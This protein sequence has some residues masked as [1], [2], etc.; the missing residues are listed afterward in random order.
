MR[1]G[2][3][4]LYLVPGM[5]HCASGPSTDQFNM[6]E[7]LVSWVEEG[8]APDRVIASARGNNAE[9]P[10]DWSTERTRPLCAFPEVARYNGSGDI[11][12]AANFSCE[13]P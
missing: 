5:G 10:A 11:E 1:M 13:A 4:R 12:D 8:V 6:F 9:I 7:A 3:A 2:F